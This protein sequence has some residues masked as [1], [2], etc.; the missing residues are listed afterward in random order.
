MEQW[1]T[2]KQQTIVVDGEASSGV[3]IVL[4]LTQGIVLVPLVV[5]LYVNDISDVS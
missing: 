3:H 5:P 1:L 4:G 2:Q